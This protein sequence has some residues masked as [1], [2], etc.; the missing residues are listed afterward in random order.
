[1]TMFKVYWQGLIPA[2]LGVCLFAPELFTL[3]KLEYI[4]D[5]F[6][7]STIPLFVGHSGLTFAACQSK[8]ELGVRSLL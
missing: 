2:S 3:F 8:T 7:L 5:H 1:M 6:S 4:R